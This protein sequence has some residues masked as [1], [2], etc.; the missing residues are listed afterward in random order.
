M[1]HLRMPLSVCILTLCTTS[2][3]AQGKPGTVE[4]VAKLARDSIVVVRTE[5][6]DGQET[7]LGSG[8]VIADGL[9]ATSL[10]VIGEARPI[11][12]QT[13]AGNRKKVTEI[14]ASDRT[15]D[16]AVLRIEDSDLPALSL[17]DEDAQLNE[18]QQVVVVGHPLG[19]ENSV[20]GGT[21][22]G[23]RNFDGVPMWQV[24][25][26]IEPGNSGG[27]LLD[28]QGRAH[29]V[30]AMK[31][32]STGNL[33][34]GFAIKSGQL[35]KLIDQP[36]P[37]S[38]DSWQ[39]IGRIDANKWSSHM[40]ARW[41]Q[42][43]GR[44][45]VEGA[46]TGFGGRALLLR[47]DAPADVPFELAVSV[48]LN[49]ES[50]AAGLVF[51]SDGQDRHYGFYPTGGRL[52]LT[53]FEG[54]DVLSWKIVRDVE[55][56]HYRPGDWN[57]IKVR[58]EKDRIVG[59]VNGNQVIAVDDV[60]QPT[61]RVGLCKFRQT[62]AEF[63]GFRHG[64]EVRSA[65][66]ARVSRD[67]L[68]EELSQ[69]G[70][71]AELTDKD[72]LPHDS[73]V[74]HR[75]AVL[76]EQ[77]R[78]LGK[79]AEQLRALREDLHTHSVCRQL[80]AIVSAKDDADID[81]LL[82]ALWI[83]KLDNP[84]LDVA[85]YVEEVDRLADAVSKRVNP[86]DTPTTKLAALD[87][88]LFEQNGFHGSRTDYYNAANSHLDRV[89]DDREGLPITLSVLYMS[90]AKRLSLN[91]VGVGLPGHFVVRHE[92]SEDKFQIIDVFSRGRRLS[93]TDAEFLV[94]QMSGQRPTDAHFSTARRADILYRMLTNLLGV[95]QRENDPPAMLRYLEGLIAI[96]PD[97]PSM[98]GMRGVLRHRQGRQQAALEDLD[99]ILATRPNGIDLR[100]VQ[101]MRDLFAE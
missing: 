67:R 59:Y 19:L 85:A 55:T 23:D 25:M 24:A 32:K 72:L 48:K 22:A 14:F 58:V 20:V 75:M 99:W 31:M 56:E 94:L 34:F 89:I 51:H 46:G 39:T 1:T 33:P 21:V 65:L 98:R 7:G 38:I 64:K 100:Q 37:I 27:P 91:V 80:R 35:R 53:S 42:R 68:V 40:G 29:G 15:L 90:I 44:T 71:R 88:Y 63:K 82:G 69:L 101:Q 47:Q 83:A 84:E 9:V 96:K 78:E 11:S 49:D 92:P 43:S 17:A 4:D 66:I 2:S 45:L 60:R 3:F 28:M 97:D 62:K 73:D 81:L 79:K 76:Q 57:E 26:T 10:H 87:R 61:G 54:P 30:V 18:G 95:A 86:D 50:G 8:F 77:A 16:L 5:D 36:N 13:R 93:Q 70:P 74:W 52:R 12:V 41:R 6:R